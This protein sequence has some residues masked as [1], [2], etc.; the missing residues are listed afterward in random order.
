VCSGRESIASGWGSSSQLAASGSIPRR[1]P[2]TRSKPPRATSRD[3][4]TPARLGRAEMP[5]CRSSTLR[6]AHH[7][8]ARRK[9]TAPREPRARAGRTPRWAIAA[10]ARA[11]AC[12]APGARVKA[13]SCQRRATVRQRPTT[14]A[15]AALTTP[16]TTPAA[17]PRVRASR[18]GHTRASTAMA[19][20][21]AGNAA[22][23]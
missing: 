20:A 14:T 1:S 5:A 12:R 18:A 9:A 21:R 4:A 3:R 19:R 15:T 16:P 7:H 2:L 8:R 6:R 17:V 11:P 23:C 13:P 22:A 10:S